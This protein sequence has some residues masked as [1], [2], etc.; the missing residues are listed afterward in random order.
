MDVG[1]GGENRSVYACVDT[2]LWRP[3]ITVRCLPQLLSTCLFE[4]EFLAEPE[5]ADGPDFLVGQL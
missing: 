1:M 4:T 5:F 2:C 3:E